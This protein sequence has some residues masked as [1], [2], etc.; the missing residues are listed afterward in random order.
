MTPSLLRV[1]LLG[2]TFW[3]VESA[4]VSA[5]DQPFV[6]GSLSVSDV[7]ENNCNA[8]DD[9]DIIND[10]FSS[11]TS[12]NG[13]QKWKWDPNETH[14]CNIRRISRPE[15]LH[16]F[17]GAG[18]PKLYPFPL[19]IYPD[20]GNENSRFANLTTL[21]NLPLNFP[22]DFHVTLSGSDSLSS[23][24]RVIPLNEYLREIITANEGSG[25][26]LPNQLGNESW[27]LFG[28]TFSQQWTTFLQSYELPPCQTCTPLHRLQS[29][30]ALSFGIG[31]TGSGVQWH[32]HGPGFSETIHGRKHWVLYPPAHRPEYDLNYASRNWMENMYPALEDWTVDDLINDMREHRVALQRW[33]RGT[34]MVYDVTEGSYSGIPERKH[35]PS[36]KKPWECTVSAGEMIYF[37][38]GWHHATINLDKYT[39]FVSSFTTE[40]D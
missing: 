34:P 25:E 22:P 36:S 10:N 4:R 26:T 18:L 20:G 27:Y 14:P 19:I 2:L 39:V 8:K 17:G 21:D 6:D 9:V 40:F 16:L 37:P 33:K 29:M 7:G 3:E 5:E 35:G 1:I 32:L 12:S 23:H 38:D 30:V 15:L 13:K 28:E 24:R 31:N 11:G